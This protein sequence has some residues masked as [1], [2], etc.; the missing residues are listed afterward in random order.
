MTIFVSHRCTC[1]SEKTK[2][3]NM[4]DHLKL[5]L[6]FSGGGYRAAT[7]HLG[8]LS[9]LHTVKTYDSNL[10]QHVVALSTISGGTL[11]GLRYMLA[12]SRGESIE[13]VFEDLYRF[14]TEV[15]LATI[16]MNNLSTY[17]KD[18]SASLIRTMAEIYNEKLFDGARL[19]TLI[20]KLNKIHIEHF[21]ANATDF[22]HGLPF[23]FQITKSTSVKQELDT[24]YGLIGNN[25]TRIPRKVA[26]HIRLSEVLATSSCFPSGFE[27][28]VFPT[29]FNL[30]E[31][32]DVKEFIE[33]TKPFGI[34]DGGIVDNQGIEPI[35]LAEQRMKTQAA[36]K[37]GKQLDLIIISDVSSPYMDAY[38]PS[39]LQIP[40][41]ISRLSLK[42]LSTNLWIAGTIATVITA[43]SIIYSPTSFLSGALFILWLLTTIALIGYFI[44][45]K[46]LIKTIKGSIV[47][48][49]VSSVMNLKFGDIATLLVNRVNS[50]LLL[51]SS[52]FMK[53]LRR[54][55]Y[56]STYNDKEW[57]NRC[58]MN[59]VYELRP[60]ENWESKAKGKQFPAYL[61]P[62]E[63]IQENSRKASAMGT[64]LWFT[65]NDMEEGV[66]DALIA[67]GQYNICWNLLEYI[68]II[69]KDPENTGPHH[70]TI[71]ACE[72]QLR[73]DWEQFQQDPLCKL[74]EW[75]K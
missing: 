23:R 32:E 47:G 62:S 18:Q 70:K 56:R 66:H 4:E 67:A 27:P 55:N 24:G 14:F 74:K 34:M 5:A 46:K 13:Q 33:K 75:K 73:A 10:L 57:K 12:L 30:G 61:K 72:Q 9:Y 71:L 43:A 65:P 58:I 39:D 19:G 42:R 38:E 51:V 3:D 40:K 49:C 60:G 35:L 7:F 2:Y 26:R 41:S 22:I 59:G 15:D 8:T 16:A 45:R 54:M 53:H 37:N 44:L 52:V 20:D 69:K 1:I 21:S 64:T 48:S 28:L 29:D 25:K 63:A 6:T 50:V 68:E 17:G 31:S 11:T 36:E